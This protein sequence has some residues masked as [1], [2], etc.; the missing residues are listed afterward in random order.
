MKVRQV[1]IPFIAGIVLFSLHGCL[2]MF[3][4]QGALVRVER[5]SAMIRGCRLMGTVRG[6]SSIGW[7]ASQK[8]E[9]ALHELRNRAALIGA[10]AVVIVSRDSMFKGTV[11][12]GKAYDCPVDR[13]Q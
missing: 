3:S 1:M 6:T 2:P 7:S 12:R 10:N 5:N 11:L 13:P 8:A 9:R 4:N